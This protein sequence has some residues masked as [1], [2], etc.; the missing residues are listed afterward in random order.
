VRRELVE[1]L[2]AA[3]AAGDRDGVEALLHPE[4][5]A[6]FTAGLPFGIG[7]THRGSDAI[8]RGWWG[9]GRSFALRVEPSEWIDCADGRLLVLGSYVGHARATR[10]PITAAYAHLLACD[11]E[12]LTSLI[13]VTDSALWLAAVDE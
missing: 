12:Q 11:G 4:F 10:R 2:Y 13:Q 3:L 9:I 8:D 6:T 7:G 1:R 5:V